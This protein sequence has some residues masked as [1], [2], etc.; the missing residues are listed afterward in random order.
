MQL[1]TSAR[2]KH[3]REWRNA[4]AKSSERVRGSR[5]THNA[6]LLLVCIHRNQLV[7]VSL[8]VEPRPPNKQSSMLDDCSYQ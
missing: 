3:L 1:V 5:S 8:Y 7:D 6:C 4:S 2:L